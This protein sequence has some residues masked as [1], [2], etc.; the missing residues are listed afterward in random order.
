MSHKPSALLLL[1]AAAIVAT[2][3]TPAAAEIGDLAADWAAGQTSFTDAV[4]AA[5][6]PATFADPKG[7]AIDRSVTP[8]RVYVS[9]SFYH[10]VLGWSDA[11][12]LTNGAPADL[13][14][15]QPDFASFGCNGHECYD[16]QT[17]L[18]TL[19]TLCDPRGMAVDG[20]GNLYVADAGNCRVL[21]FLDPFGTDQ[22]ADYVLGQTSGLCDG[23]ATGGRLYDPYDVAV[24]PAGNVFVSDTLHC[25]VLEYDRPLATD[26]VADRVFGQA[27]FT[28]QVC[29]PDDLS[30]LY[31][32]EGL[33]I[34]PSGNLYVASRAGINEF[35][36]PLATDTITDRYIGNRTCNPGGESASTTC[37]PIGVASGAGGQ[38]F[39]ADVNNDRILEFD[40]PLTSSQANR[41]F[42]Q[43]GFTNSSGTLGGD[44]NFGGLSASSLC[45]RKLYATAIALDSNGRLYV[46]D[47][48]NQRVLRYD[49]PLSSDAVADTVLGQTA[50]NE[51]R[52][53]T[54]PVDEPRVTA[55]DSDG[56]LLVLEPNNSRILVYGYLGTPMAAFGQPDIYTTGCN[57]GGLSASSLCNPTAATVDSGGRLWVADSGNNRILE[58]NIVW[59]YYNDTTKQFEVR[60]DANRVFG[61]PGFTSNACGSGASGLCDPRGVDL[62]TRLNLYISDTG[63][64]RIVHHQNPFADATAEHVYGQADFN[65]GACNAGGLGADSLCDPREIAVDA[66]GNL[67][68]V[69]RGNNRVVVY[70]DVFNN[71]GGADRIFGQASATTAACGAGAAGLCAPTSLSLDRAGNL[72]VADTDNN[73]VVVYDAP[74]TSDS[75]A[76]RVFGQPDLV[77]TTC[78]TGGVSASSLCRPLG[79]ATAP[80]T[81]VVFVADAGNE[82]VLRFDAPYCIGDFVL[83]PATRAIH[84]IHSRPKWTTVRVHDGA[85]VGD[86]TLSFSGRARILDADGRVGPSREPLVTLS[87]ANGIVFQQRVPDLDTRRGIVYKTD[88]LKGEIASG[89]D[90]F[91]IAVHDVFPL[92]FAGQAIGFR[93][94]AVG[95]DMSGFTE[96]AATFKLRFGSRCFTTE[97]ACKDTRTGRRCSAAR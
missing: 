14:I 54:A 70:A 73:R 19:S 72:L 8:N 25:R 28:D 68:V 22:V 37:A 26:T 74:L 75:S 30:Y 27:N 43:P 38:L 62:D 81:D 9:D 44:C 20:A 36:N 60:R 2:A 7:V 77:T 5:I 52:K 86:D 79:V 85:T 93:G 42:G 4:A 58:Y 65:G 46:A 87:T 23:L 50:M 84:G 91:R 33:S 47:A 88:Y 29:E 32:P 63:N 90:Y 57:T 53:P 69:D 89:I 67:F 61:Q 78:N 80:Y 59:A 24:D 76:D 21:I 48:A 45:T 92:P 15:G 71:G 82:R 3:L 94:R 95:Q 51:A 97:L 12:A 39:V 31:Y 83:S 41:V 66:G 18:P 64:N 96:T 6:G 1:L 55:S 35:D 13:V 34:D 56:L 11:D 49:A 17:P 40:T 16:L 10:R